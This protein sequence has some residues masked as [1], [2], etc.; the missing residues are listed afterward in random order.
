MLTSGASMPLVQRHGAA[1]IRR[2]V[3]ADERERRLAEILE[4]RSLAEELRID[5]HAESVAVLLA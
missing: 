4:R 5:G 3:V 1:G 2:V